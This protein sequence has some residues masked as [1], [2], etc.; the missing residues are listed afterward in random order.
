MSMT[1]DRRL[2]R[3]FVTL[4]DTLVVD[5][6]VLDFLALLAERSVEHLAV[7]AAGVI[8]SDQRGGWRPAAGSSERADLLELFTAQT[9]EGPC[10][11]CVATGKPVTCADL[12]TAGAQTRWPRFSLAAAGSGFRAASAVPMRL[13]DQTVGALT[14]LNHEPVTLDPDTIEI[15]QALADVATIGILHQHAAARGELVAEQLE[16]TLQQRTV[17]EQAKGVLA[18]YL[19][20][21]MHDAFTRLREYSHHHQRRLSEV[22]RDLAGGTL[23]PS[24][25][26]TT[27]SWPVEDQPA[28]PPA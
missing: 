15:G 5:F 22:A 12:R 20:F 25:F 17:I 7:D 3:T 4:A 23:R 1:A 10:F 9:R 8:L 16:A 2:A 26:A 21:D 13:R 11:D 24:A 18:E 14:L 28:S 19:A 6:D 27:R